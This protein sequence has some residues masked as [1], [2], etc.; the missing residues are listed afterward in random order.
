MQSDYGFSMAKALAQGWPHIHARPLH[1]VWAGSVALGA[2]LMGLG[3]I[4][5]SDFYT[6]TVATL[7]VVGI[8]MLIASVAQTGHALSVRGLV[9]PAGF[10][11]WLSS[12]LLYGV[13]GWLAFKNPSLAAAALTLALAFALAVSGS[14]RIWWG[15]WL[16]VLP[17]WGSIAASGAITS[18][19][20]IVFL[21]GWPQDALWLLG[22][23]LAVD[24][25]FQGAMAIAFGLAL[26]QLRA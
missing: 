13:A 20:G 15:F 12:A 3:V 2:A 8:V 24:L 25:A 21:L 16:R 26:R 18:L 14:M 5:A 22:L 9:S 1:S 19:A 17:G 4:A 6:A 23:V 10:L 7:H 11:A